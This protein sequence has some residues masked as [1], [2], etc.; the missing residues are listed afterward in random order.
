M[1]LLNNMKRT[2]DRVRKI[3][4][5]LKNID[6]N[7]RTKLLEQLKNDEVIT[8][9]EYHRLLT[10]KNDVLSSAKAFQGSGVWV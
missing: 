1:I 5:S 9:P 4:N 6:E 10:S 3:L 8:E 7:E 2:A